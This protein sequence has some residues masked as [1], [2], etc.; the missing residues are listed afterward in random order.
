MT[1]THLF[2]KYLPNKLALFQIKSA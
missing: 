2:A 1:D